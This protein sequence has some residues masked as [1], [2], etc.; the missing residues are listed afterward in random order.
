METVHLARNA[1]V[2]SYPRRDNPDK[3]PLAVPSCSH[4]PAGVSARASSTNHGGRRPVGPDS[5]HIE[6][7]SQFGRAL[8]YSTG[9][10]NHFLNVPAG[11]VSAF[12]DQPDNFPEWLGNL[13]DDERGGTP[14]TAGAFA[15]RGLFGA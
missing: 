1:Q 9:N 2:S 11:R 10:A 13:P 3:I 4:I 14:A 5:D 8:A 15:P 6:R 12:H 7:N